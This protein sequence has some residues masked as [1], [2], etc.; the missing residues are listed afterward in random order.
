[1]EPRFPVERPP[2][3]S[4]RHDLYAVIHKA[5]RL[6]M[7]DALARFGRMDPDDAQQRA[8]AIECVRSMLELA[9]VHIDDENRFVHPALDERCAEAG[10][11]TAR[12]HVGHEREID[13]LRAELLALERAAPE[14]RGMHALQLYRRLALYVAENFVHM[15]HEETHNMPALW[16]RYAD[17]ELLA[18][19]RAIIAS[20]EPQ[21]MARFLRWMLPALPHPGRVALLPPDAPAELVDLALGIVGEH[22]GPRERDRL[23]AEWGGAGALPRAA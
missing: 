17:D 7:T 14:S 16:A 3:E 5:L 19:E 8:E 12:E 20:I 10:E 18:I 6:C 15:H 4:S 2:L 13:A 11:R 9:A 21:T 1:M 23:A 22:L